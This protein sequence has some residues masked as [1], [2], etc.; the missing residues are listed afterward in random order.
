MES[1]P[2]RATKAQAVRSASTTPAPTM[3]PI[4][5]APPREGGSRNSSRRPTAKSAARPAL[6]G[7]RKL[8]STYIRVRTRARLAPGDGALK[9]WARAGAAR[10]GSRAGCRALLVVAGVRLFRAGRVR[11]AGGGLLL[12]GHARRLLRLVTSG[13]TRVV[14]HLF[15]RRLLGQLVG[16]LAPALGH[17]PPSSG[18]WSDSSRRLSVTV[19]PPR[20]GS[21]RRSPRRPRAPAPRPGPAGRRGR[22]GPAPWP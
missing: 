22:S 16:L 21:P 17:G 15:R 8:S 1:L 19:R 11:V 4:S 13:A 6:M 3:I 9:R 12:A 5:S 7:P 2:L 10:E 14:R 20:R 18:S